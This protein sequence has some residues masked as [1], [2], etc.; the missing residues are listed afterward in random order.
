[1]GRV[2]QRAR[3]QFT[4]RYSYSLSLSVLLTPY[5]AQEILD[6][7]L[8]DADKTTVIYVFYCSPVKWKLEV[9][10]GQLLQGV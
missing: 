7:T 3:G 9:I 10:Q 4:G 5:L 6:K 2:N 8:S 1:M